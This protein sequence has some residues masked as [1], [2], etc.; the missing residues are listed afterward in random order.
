MS[1]TTNLCVSLPGERFVA[2]IG[3]VHPC[4]EIKRE[5]IHQLCIRPMAHSELVKALPENVSFFF[6]I[7]QTFYSCPL[8]T[9]FRMETYM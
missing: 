8:N 5:V 1:Y 6:F 4:D 7:I 2:G 3:Q 9:V